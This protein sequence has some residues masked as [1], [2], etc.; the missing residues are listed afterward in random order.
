MTK[1]IFLLT[2]L[3]S[4]AMFA[5]STPATEALDALQ[6]LKSV[7]E[8]GVNYRDYTSRVVDAKVKVDK[9]LATPEKDDA[10]VRAKVDLAM[11]AYVVAGKLWYGTIF[12]RT[13]AA[14]G[15][16]EI[17]LADTELCNCTA[18][19]VGIDAAKQQQANWRT[20]PRPKG[21]RKVQPKDDVLNIPRPELAYFAGKIPPSI[22][23]QCAAET[24]AK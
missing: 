15:A 9:Y 1:R 13:S 2:A 16:G 19:K 4:G 7:T 18:V 17:L 11:R 21:F 5:Q 22:L 8:I 23:W 14:D 24:L 20:P 10:A 6:A 3:C 12:S